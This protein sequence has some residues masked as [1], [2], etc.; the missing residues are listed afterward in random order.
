[1]F[2]PKRFA[3]AVL[4]LAALAFTQ[5]NKPAADAPGGAATTA[6]KSAAPGAGA[7]A[8]SVA[9]ISEGASPAFRAVA[10]H[11]ELGGRSYEY[12]EAGGAMALATFLD[13]M[14]KA[15]PERERR[16]IP[17]GFTVAKLFHLL[18]LDAIAATGSSAR[19]RADG[20]FHSRSFAYMPQGRKG[21]LTLSGGP[22]AKLMLL[23]IAP[24]DT[25]LALEFPLNLKDF[26]REGLPEILAMIPPAERAE[27]DQQMSQ[28]IPPLGLSGKQIVEKLD[29]R[30]G[31][32]LRLDP[33]QKIQISPSDPPMPGVDGIIAI[34][35]L[36]WLVEALKPQ[37]MP[38]L[39]QPGLPVTV[40][41]EG[42]VLTVRM[43]SPAGPPPMDFQ[44]VVRFDSKADRILIATRAALFD[45]VVA[46]TAKITQGADFTQAWRDLPSEGNASIYASPRLLQ[47][48]SDL[49]AK[50]AQGERGASPADVIV[51][52]KIFD[53]VK[54]FLSRGQ[55][56]VIANQPDGILTLSNTS[57]PAAGPTMTAVS[58]VAVL[59]GMTFPVLSNARGRAVEAN[60]LN[61]LRQVQMGL[62]MYASDNGKYPAALSELAP[63]YIGSSQILEF[64][65]H[66]TKQRMAWLYRNSLTETSPADEVLVASPVAMPDGKRAVGFNDGSVRIIPD[67]EFQTLWSRK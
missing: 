17:A 48:I 44:P 51:M 8:N 27:F 61:A 21:L 63:K 22:A 30:I 4:G 38:M 19:A 6:P 16:D 5:C 37:F 45:S 12:S 66:S 57:I 3:Q 18:G 56:V 65:D 26:A 39:S 15:L 43:K 1:M 2:H 28:P 35:R 67:A 41:D 58:T 13:E 46:G 32:F 34:D 64:T 33:T 47:M 53:V 55:A 7:S 24:K 25:D 62:K 49:I 23:D 50:A 14:M 52:R 29:A 60:D 36:G 40:T 59:A 20:S 10:S 9:V 31:I 42:G 11:L 54:P